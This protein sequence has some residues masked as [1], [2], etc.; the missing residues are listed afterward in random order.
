MVS[1]ELGQLFT[2]SLADCFGRR[3]VAIIGVVIYGVGTGFDWFATSL[4]ALLIARILQGFGACVTSVAAFAAV[5][6]SFEGK[7]AGQM[8]SYLNGTIC[9][10]PAL[11]P[12]LRAWL[13]QTLGLRAN[14]GFMFLYAIFAYIYF[15]V[16][17]DPQ[18]L[19]SM[20]IYLVQH[21]IGAY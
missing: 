12:L 6:D 5:R 9:F 10:I 21:V 14:F 2:G 4:D 20:E 19:I 1:L 13:A 7:R 3:P 15:S 16:K 18:M 8:I 11:A 17:Q